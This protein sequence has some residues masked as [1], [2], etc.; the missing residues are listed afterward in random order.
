MNCGSREFKFKA[1]GCLAVMAEA[2]GPYDV[3]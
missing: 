1:A 2:E 3:I